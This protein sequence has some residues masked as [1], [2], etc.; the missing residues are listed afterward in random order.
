M[1]F[2]FRKYGRAGAVLP[3]LCAVACLRAPLFTT[4]VTTTA[5]PATSDPPAAPVTTG[6]SKTLAVARR[7]TIGGVACNLNL[8]IPA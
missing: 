4:P 6:V 2:R 5:K 1:N 7:A 3:A 8:T